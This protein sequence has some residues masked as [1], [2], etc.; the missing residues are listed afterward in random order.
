[1]IHLAATTAHLKRLARGRKPAL[2][3][4]AA[5]WA[6]KPLPPLPERRYGCLVT[7][8][9]FGLTGGI[10]TGKS[11]VATRFRE[12]CAPVVDADALAREAVAPTSEGFDRV[13]ARFGRTVVTERGELDRKALAAL[14]FNDDTARRELNAIVHPRVREL[15]Q[16]RFSELD[17]QGEPLAC[18]E[19]PLLVEVG[20]AEILRPLVVVTA[21][22]S[23]QVAR[24]MARDRASEAAVRSRI[25]AQLPLSEKVK[26]ADFVIDNAGSPERTKQRADEVLDAICAQFRIDTARYPKPPI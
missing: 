9:V 8:R 4:T 1:M 6:A 16:E 23:V 13:V 7:L 17:R 26:L 20:L 19:V 2:T 25:E 3:G 18:Y 22:E 12:R 15:A 10:G 14:V 5:G 24:T 21:P 11:S